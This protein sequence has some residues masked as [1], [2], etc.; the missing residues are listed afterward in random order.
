MNSV[1]LWSE[2]QYCFVTLRFAFVLQEN[3]EAYSRTEAGM[4]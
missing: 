3:C 4:T 1:V 2:Q